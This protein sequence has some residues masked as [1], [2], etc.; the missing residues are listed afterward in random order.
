MQADSPLQRKPP[1]T[2]SVYYAVAGRGDGGGG[3]LLLTTGIAAPD[4]ATAVEE[5]GERAYM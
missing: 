5:C 3:D 1:S 2:A 4:A